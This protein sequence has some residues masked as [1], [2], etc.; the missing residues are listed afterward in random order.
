MWIIWPVMLNNIVV[1]LVFIQLASD[2]TK[3]SYVIDN[4]CCIINLSC[5]LA[6]PIGLSLQFALIIVINTLTF[7]S[8]SFLNYFSSVSL[9]PSLLT[10]S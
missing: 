3:N 7:L 6:S 10:S 1:Q 2:L 9:S 4:I 5:R 8:C